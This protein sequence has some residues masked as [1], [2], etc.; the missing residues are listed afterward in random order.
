MVSFTVG[1]SNCR[2]LRRKS[3]SRSLRKDFSPSSFFFSTMNF[4]RDWMARLTRSASDAVVVLLFS[5][6]MRIRVVCDLF[7]FLFLQKAYLFSGKSVDTAALS[8]L[9]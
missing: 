7:R 4:L 8:A 1:S 6:M 9:L 2:L 3:V 5:R